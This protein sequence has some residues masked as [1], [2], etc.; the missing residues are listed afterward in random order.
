MKPGGYRDDI[1]TLSEVASSI[2]L[3]ETID[4]EVSEPNTEMVDI[5]KVFSQSE[6]SKNGNG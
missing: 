3:T 4:A 5:V 2:S 1:D 6:A